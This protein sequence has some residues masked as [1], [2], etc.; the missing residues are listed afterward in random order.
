MDPL[1]GCRWVGGGKAGR[2]GAMQLPKK[3]HR[4]SSAQPLSAIGRRV[5]W[6]ITLM[7]A[8]IIIGL[9]TAIIGRMAPIISPLD[10]R[11][12]TPRS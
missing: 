6:L 10:L 8:I 3:E 12:R 5:I 2:V 7:T 1:G 4:Q 9:M 11:E